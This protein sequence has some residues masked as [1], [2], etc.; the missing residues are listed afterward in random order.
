M[1]NPYLCGLAVATLLLFG[2]SAARGQSTTLKI[3]DSGK[4]VAAHEHHHAKVGHKITWTRQT[5]KG[6]PWFVRFAS[7]PCAEGAEFGSDR[8]KTCT[9]KVACSKAGDAGC[10]SYT[11]NSATGPNAQLNDPD[12]IV[13]P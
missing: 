11:Y 10:K 13:D 4:V 12:I 5:G 6:K 2:S 7:S 8:A 3:D 9:I 1:Q